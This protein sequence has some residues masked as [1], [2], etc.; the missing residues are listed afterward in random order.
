MRQYIQKA[1][2]IRSGNG[3]KKIEDTLPDRFC[4]VFDGW[5]SGDTHYLAIF[6]TYPAETT[7]GYQTVLLTFS[8]MGDETKLD[9]EEQVKFI[10]KTLSF[11]KKG[12]DNIICVI[13][14]NCPVNKRTARL[15]SVPMVGCASHRFNLAVMD[16][17]GE[18]SILIEKVR[19]VM[20][21]LRQL[22]PAAKL[23]EH[24][25]LKEKLACPTR[26]GSYY[27]MLKRFY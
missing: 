21:V 26:W 3:W 25:K 23:R 4:I 10:H 1:C 5:S 2:G 9:A 8:P 15:I 24:T 22:I 18:N 13:A 14:D 17:V 7:D 12:I 27:Q 20:V 16:I 19:N 6:A 11:Y